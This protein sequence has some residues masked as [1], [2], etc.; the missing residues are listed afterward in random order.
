MIHVGGTSSKDGI[1][2]KGRKYVVKFE[3]ANNSQMKVWMTKNKDEKMN[4]L[5]SKISNIPILRSAAVLYYNAK[6][7]Y[8]LV[9]TLI[10]LEFVYNKYIVTLD[11]SSVNSGI[12]LRIGIA[13]VW[14]F[15]LWS[16]ANKLKGFKTFLGY[17]GAEHKVINTNYLKQ[18]INYENCKKASRIGA[19]CGTMYAVIF[20]IV[21]GIILLINLRLPIPIYKSIQ[22]FFGMLISLE[23]FGID[24]RNK[25]LYPIFKIGYLFQEKFLTTEPDDFKLMAAIKAFTILERAEKSELSDEEMETLLSKDGVLVNSISN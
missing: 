10:I 20:L 3:M 15:N 12:G 9:F 8:V 14:I 5:F 24:R 23:I 18:E 22:F 25:V 17:H 6:I 4:G 16:W 11:M 19:D 21:E 2:F 13:I 7:A 1:E